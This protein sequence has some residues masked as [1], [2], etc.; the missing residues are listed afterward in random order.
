MAIVKYYF[1][2]TQ[3]GNGVC[4][5]RISIDEIEFR[6]IEMQ[7]FLFT[8][9]SPSVASKQAV[10]TI[11]TNSGL[12]FNDKALSLIGRSS[13]GV[14]AFKVRSIR[15]HNFE[16]C[17]LNTF[18]VF[19]INC[20]RESKM[21]IEFRPMRSDR[22]PSRATKNQVRST[23]AKTAMIIARKNRSCLCPDW[24]KI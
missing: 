13:N 2:S 5:S 19:V 10:R 16:E 7:F 15:S 24:E 6:A 23:T 9:I 14:F 12:Q 1:S 22:I 11:Y 4:K 18:G 3:S 17:K 20:S 21:P 8:A